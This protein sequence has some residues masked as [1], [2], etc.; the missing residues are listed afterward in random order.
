MSS[1][2]HDIFEQLVC[3]RAQALGVCRCKRLDGHR[4][5]RELIERLKLGFYAGARRYPAVVCYQFGTLGAQ[6]KIQQERGS[7]RA[8]S[9][10]RNGPRLGG[11]NGGGIGINN[12]DR[13]SR[14]LHLRR[15]VQVKLNA[16]LVFAGA[17]E[18][19]LKCMTA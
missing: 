17:Q 11:R 16:D 12:I 19:G 7:V 4:S 5:T 9:G 10:K 2:K 8:W 13:T 3:G 18:L 1:S 6:N 15:R 14:A